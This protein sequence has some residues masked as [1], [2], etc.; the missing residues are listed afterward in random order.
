[1]QRSILLKQMLDEMIT[2]VFHQSCHAH[3]K[4]GTTIATGKKSHSYI[5]A[6]YVAMILMVASVA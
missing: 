4:A 6:I 1:M 2:I 3:T 5:T